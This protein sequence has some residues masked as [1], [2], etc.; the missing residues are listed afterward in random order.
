VPTPSQDSDDGKSL[1]SE[2]ELDAEQFFGTQSQF[3]ENMKQFLTSQNIS[4]QQNLELL[5]LRMN[6]ITPLRQTDAEPMKLSDNATAIGTQHQ[7]LE[8]LRRW[9]SPTSKNSKL[10]RETNIIP[11]IRY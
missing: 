9:G 2:E 5:A 8:A 11:N 7:E 6:R 3:F 1:D 10:G 4:L